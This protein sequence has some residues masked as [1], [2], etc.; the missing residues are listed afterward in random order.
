MMKKCDEI[1]KKDGTIIEA[2]VKHIDVNT[3]TYL[4]CKKF[5]K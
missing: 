2:K 1:I 4:N 3:V 5:L